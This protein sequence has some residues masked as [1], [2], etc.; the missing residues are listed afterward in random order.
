[1][2]SSL[3]YNAGLL[4]VGS[5]TPRPTWMMTFQSAPMDVRDYLAEELGIFLSE[6]RF[7][8]AI[9]SHARGDSERVSIIFDRLYLLAGMVQPNS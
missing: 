1:M 2:L 3:N 7:E 8:D 9:N 4:S 5:N 6:E